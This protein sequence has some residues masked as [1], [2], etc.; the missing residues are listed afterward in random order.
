[1][2]LELTTDRY[3][4]IM[5]KMGYQLHHTAIASY[6]GFS[7]P[8]I[9]PCS[10]NTVFLKVCFIFVQMRVQA[11]LCGFF[12]FRNSILPKMMKCVCTFCI[13]SIRNII[14]LLL[15]SALKINNRFIT[16]RKLAS[17]FQLMVSW[18][19]ELNSKYYDLSKQLQKKTQ[20]F[21]ILRQRLKRIKIEIW[22]KSLYSHYLCYHFQHKGIYSI[23]FTLNGCGS[24][25]CL[26]VEQW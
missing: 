21:S 3:P 15:I 6:L 12:C 4:P 2:G 26:S 7:N 20:R 5:I 9:S 23:V 10:M 22:V 13:A 8:L 14:V 18:D 17:L 25:M 1:M 24:L 19:V 16:Y 11:H